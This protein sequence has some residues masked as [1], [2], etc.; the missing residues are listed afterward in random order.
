M[1]KEDEKLEQDPI[2]DMLEREFGKEK[3]RPKPFVSSDEELERRRAEV[4]GSRRNLF[5]QEEDEEVIPAWANLKDQSE[6]TKARLKQAEERRKLR[7]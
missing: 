7:R 6:A 2:A 4:D 5:H 3:A 1:S